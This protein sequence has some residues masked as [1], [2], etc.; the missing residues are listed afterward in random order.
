MPAARIR[1]LDIAHA[2]DKESLRQFYHEIYLPAFPREEEREELS[3]WENALGDFSAV[4]T[5]VLLAHHGMRL[6]GGAVVEYYPRSMVGLLTY[7]VIKPTCRHQGLGRL[8]VEHAIGTVSAAC[9]KGGMLRQPAAFLAEATDPGTSASDRRRIEIAASLGFAVLDAPYIQP[10][11]RQRTCRAYGLV[12]MA[13]RGCLG[14]EGLPSDVLRGFIE[15]F[16]TVLE[17]RPS[18][19]DE[20]FAM[21]IASIS[22]GTH[23]PLR[24]RGSQ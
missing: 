24:T 12:L 13:H 22:N 14:P 15:E 3:D 17:G 1:I 21:Q 20:E 9:Q 2:P 18:P 11:L 16:Y 5:H 19:G 6:A 8:L 10:R 23:V 7:L 4:E